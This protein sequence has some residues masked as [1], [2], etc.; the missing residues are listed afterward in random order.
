MLTRNTETRAYGKPRLFVNSGC[1]DLISELMEINEEA[2]G[3]DY[4]VDGL[5]YVLMN[6]QNVM[7]EIKVFSS[8]RSYWQILF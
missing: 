8:R 3:N 5:R 2:K 1:V 4:A 7:R 6:R